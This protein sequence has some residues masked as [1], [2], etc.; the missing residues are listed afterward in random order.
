MEVAIFFREGEPLPE[1]I[2]F[3]FPDSLRIHR[4]HDL[5]YI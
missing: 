3:L 2:T 4:A 1:V 5:P